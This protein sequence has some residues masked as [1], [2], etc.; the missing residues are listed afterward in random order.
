MVKALDIFTSTI[1]ALYY[2]TQLFEGSQE[3]T[4]KFM[5]QYL[6][7]ASVSSLFLGLIFGYLTDRLNYRRF[8]APAFLVICVADLTLF[9]APD[10]ESPWV[11]V[12]LALASCIT[13]SS[14]LLV[15]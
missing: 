14:N 5:N 15:T 4:S 8:P 11:V 7:A 13:F 3:R 10:M 1:C 12:V 6:G 9:F 2:N